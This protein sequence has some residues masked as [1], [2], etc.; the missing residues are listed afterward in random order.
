MTTEILVPSGAK[1]VINDAPLEI[2]LGLHDEIDIALLPHNISFTKLVKSYSNMIAEK[3]KNG[4]DAIY[5]IDYL[6]LEG[7]GQAILAIKSSKKVRE[8]VM[9]CLI[10]CTYNDAKI[11]KD[12]FEKKEAR[13][14]YNP[15]FIAVLKENV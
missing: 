4:I 15:I 11:T 13:G 1:V 8:K 6:A 3:Q 2:A 10:R 14:D 9:E 12:T 7:V 5:W